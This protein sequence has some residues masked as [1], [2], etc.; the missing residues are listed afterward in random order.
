MGDLTV[1]TKIKASDTVCIHTSETTDPETLQKPTA[2]SRYGTSTP[3]D[4]NRNKVC[5]N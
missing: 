3:D 4:E 1:D 2:I 5:Y